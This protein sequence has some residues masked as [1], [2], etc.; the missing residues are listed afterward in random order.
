MRTIKFRAWHKERKQMVPWGVLHDFLRGKSFVVV[1]RPKDILQPDVYY[2]RYDS[3][4][5]IFESKDFEIMQFT[6]LKDK[7]GK[8][9]YE[10]DYLDHYGLEYE[11]I[12]DHGSW[13]AKCLTTGPNPD[14]TESKS[15]DEYLFDSYKVMEIIG[16][17]Y[18][19]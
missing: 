3:N 12:F 10:G 13:I 1:E 8:E 18:E 9:I 7:N 15:P 4:F 2:T 16:N 6:G 19:K 11:V 17:K 5:N 14:G